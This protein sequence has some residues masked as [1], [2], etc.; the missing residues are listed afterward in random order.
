M[1]TIQYVSD[2]HLE[3]LSS[4][5][6][7]KLTPSQGA[8]VLVLA[9]DIGRPGSKLYRELLT[10]ATTKFE[11]ILMILGNHECYGLSVDEALDKLKEMA[12]DFTN[13]HVLAR[14]VWHHPIHNVAFAG[15]TL[16]SNIDVTAYQVLND[17]R[18]IK[19]HD[20]ELMSQQDFLKLHQIDVEFFERVLEEYNR[21]DYQ[22]VC[23][24]HHAPLMSMNGKSEGDEATTGFCSALNTLFRP[25][26]VA[27]ICGHTHQSLQIKE[28]DIPCVSNC[29][30]YKSE[31]GCT[32]YKTGASIEIK[33]VPPY[34][35]RCTR[36]LPPLE[37]EGV[38]VEGE[39]VGGR[40]T[41]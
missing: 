10:W 14:D 39:G 17:K 15:A 12:K 7:A 18:C 41:A 35:L 40:P 28:N 22:V 19:S 3:H 20:G 36:D 32:G 16:W 31:L 4:V 11:H 34:F 33:T 21:S 29:L 27:W 25:P 2:I 8:H 5:P 26:L 9:G 37:E 6:F 38:E 13:V 1:L 23:I 24:S 30:G